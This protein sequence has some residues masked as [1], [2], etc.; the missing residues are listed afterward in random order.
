MNE[1]NIYRFS[2]IG[3]PID[4]DYPSN[5]AIT[6]LSLVT[7]LLGIIYQFLGGQNWLD[8][9]LWGIGLG[10]GVFLAWAICRELDPD[11]DL[12]AFVAAGLTLVGVFLWGTPSIIGLLWLM[13]CV[14]IINRTVGLPATILDSLGV[15]G[16]GTWLS[17]QEYWGYGVITSLAFLLDALLPKPNK[18]QFLFTGV[19]LIVSALSA[20]LSAGGVSLQGLSLSSGAVALGITV[21]FLPVIFASRE[22]QVECDVTKEPPEPIRV[23]MG[24]VVAILGGWIAVVWKGESGLISMLPLWTSALG[25]ALYWLV[26]AIVAKAGFKSAW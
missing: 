1:I 24:Q 13:L 10:L 5:L 7:M 2:S 21:V 8:S 23:Q 9:I 14:R 20:F 16:L 15:L 11:H 22:I 25:A 12:S 6:A 19:M 18:R 26:M 3:R 4:P 17:I